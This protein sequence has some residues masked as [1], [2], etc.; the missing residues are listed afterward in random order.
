[1]SRLSRA[2]QARRHRSEARAEGRAASPPAQGPVSSKAAAVAPPAAD[3]LRR[4][5]RLGHRVTG[6][7][8]GATA[9]Q[10]TLKRWRPKNDVPED[11]EG[12]DDKVREVDGAVDDAYR[13]VAEQLKESKPKQ[14][15]G[16]SDRRFSH[17][18]DV[19]GQ[20]GA[21]NRKAAATGYI[22]EDHATVGF[23]S[24]PMVTV[25][26]TGELKNSRPDVVVRDPTKGFFGTTGYLDI[27]STGDAGHIFDKEG[28]WGKRPY[29]A[30]SLYPS[31]DFS[32]L[33]EGPL[34]VDEETLK[35]VE[36]WRLQRAQRRWKQVKKAYESRKKTFESRQDLLVNK[37]EN[38]TK[39]ARLRLRDPDPVVRGSGSLKVKVRRPK[40]RYEPYSRLGRHETKTRSEMK[41]YGVRIDREGD[42]VRISFETILDLQDIAYTW[43]HIKELYALS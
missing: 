42:V 43:E 10:R 34:E 11:Y 40:N 16:V 1:M 19:L 17:W 12:V 27:T 24:D 3:L 13:V 14:L 20:F 21:S 35:K 25:Q 7:V 33:S 32:N 29:V 18:V 5:E 22:I 9:V 15:D 31:L 8:A 28:N 41:E 23:A 2:R 26:V 36:Q 37:L 38:W 6:A 4:A 39:E 30:E